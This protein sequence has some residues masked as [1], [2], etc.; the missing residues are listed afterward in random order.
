MSRHA[1]VTALR[2]G[3]GARRGEIAAAARDPHGRVQAQIG[4]PVLLHGLPSAA[5]LAREFME[6]RG[7]IRSGAGDETDLAELR[8]RQRAVIVAE[9][10]ARIRAGVTTDRPFSERLARFWANHFTV[11]VRKGGIAPIVGAFQREAIRPHV[12]GRF[13]DMLIAAVSHPA[14]IV[15]LDNQRS[16]GPNSRLGRRRGLGLNENLAREVLELHT[17]GVNGG[18]GQADVEGLAK[19]LTGWTVAPREHFPDRAGDFLFLEPAHEPG[20]HTVLG[21]RYAPHG[22]GQGLQALRDLARHPAAARH[23]ATKM[24]QHFLADEPPAELVEALTRRFL[25]SGGDLAAMAQTLTWAQPAWDAPLAKVKPPEDYLTASLRLFD[26][27]DFDVARLFALMT[28]MGQKPLAPP[29]PDGWPDG[30]MDWASPDALM[31]RIEWADLGGARICARVDPRTLA[32][33]AFGALIS[34]QTEQSVA[35]AAD[36]AQGAALVLLAPEMLRR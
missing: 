13:E 11:S 26:H 18:Y 12:Y 6:R 10:Q 16:F 25:D 35:R 24:A 1:A 7:R 31:R 5:S 23:L 4:H 32:A 28:A 22:Q 14:M 33:E 9:L 34:T 3:L 20:A 15:Y 19:I 29:G 27:R 30:E 8:E 17:L 36:A 2:F 21:R